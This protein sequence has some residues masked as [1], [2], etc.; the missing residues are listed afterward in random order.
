ME[1]DYAKIRKQFK[2]LE[3]K[4]K[5]YD[6]IVV[7]RHVKPDFDAFGSQMGLVY[8]IKANFP[9]KEVHFVGEGS[10]KW[11]PSLYPTPEK[12]E[13]SWFAQGPFLAIIT[14]C[15]NTERVSDNTMGRSTFKIKIDHHPEV[16][17]YGD[18]NIVYP[19]II[20]ASE[21]VALFE[22]SRS[23][24]Y[25][26]PKESAEALFSG[27]VGDSGRFLYDPT[28]AA[29]FRIVGDLVDLGIDM[30]GVYNKMYKKTK[31]DFENL[32]FVLNNTKFTEHGVGYYILT[33]AD[34]NNL[35][36]TPI[37]G[38]MFVNEFR[39]LDGLFI[40]ASI[41]ENKEDN[42]FRVSIR[43]KFVA[44]DKI[45]TQFRGGGH[46]NA[47]GATLKSLDEVPALIAALDK[48]VIDYKASLTIKENN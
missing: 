5:E 19:D 46:A 3:K 22:L 39:D 7:Y 11:C 12:L 20:A 9:K 42:T 17:R 30:N 44:I 14:D 23:N 45:A 31:K 29:T 35:G 26:I 33:D 16:D 36:I 25:T 34:L 47:S 18:L 40:T 28:D 32:K 21:I 15:A 1:F 6:R 10:E 13:E 37:D 24:H 48:A 27:I 2:E 4:I 41:T 43:S 38:K 8:W